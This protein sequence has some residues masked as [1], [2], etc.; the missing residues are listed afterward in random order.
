L[1]HGLGH[2]YAGKIAR[3]AWVDASNLKSGYRLL[4]D[5]GSWAEVQSVKVESKPLTAYNLTVRDY[6]TYF[7]TGNAGAEPVWVHNNCGKTPR[8]VDRDE[9]TIE[10]AITG[11]NGSEVTVITNH[12]IVGDRLIL[13]GLHIDGAGR[14]TSSVR[15]LREVA[16]AVG[17]QNGVKEVVIRGGTRTTGANPGHIPREIKVR[18]I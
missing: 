9:D 10:Y 8:I 17:K 14:G 12:R 4:N 1:G 2:S 3:G 11:R 16:R 18:I 13:E 7:V 15:E 5:D 6:H